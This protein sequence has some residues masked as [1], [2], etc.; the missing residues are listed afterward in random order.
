MTQHC[1][2]V[3]LNK[4]LSENLISMA[5]C[6]DVQSRQQKVKGMFHPPKRPMAPSTL[7][8]MSQVRWRKD[9]TVI[10]KG[11]N[12]A[13]MNGKKGTV[14]LVDNVLGK[15]QVRIEDMDKLFKVKFENVQMAE[16]D[17]E[18]N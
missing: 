16:E 9:D 7:A 6:R 2:L 5:D 17:E 18:L 11:L 14:V 10:L 13:E 15:V 1:D 3:E 12:Q 4:F 8:N